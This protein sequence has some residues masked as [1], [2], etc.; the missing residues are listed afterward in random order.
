MIS[1]PIELDHDPV[2]EQEVGTI[3]ARQRL[4]REDRN[5]GMH[6]SEPE[7][8]LQRTVAARTEQPEQTRVVPRKLR[9]ERSELLDPQQGALRMHRSLNHSE[10][11]LRVET[12]GRDIERDGERLGDLGSGKSEPGIPVQHHLLSDGTAKRPH[13]ACT[14]AQ[15][16]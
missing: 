10:P 3:T 15:P 5:A 13:T 6:H 11:S 4:L 2:V 7:H 14:V 1:P 12:A 16:G 8:R 9:S